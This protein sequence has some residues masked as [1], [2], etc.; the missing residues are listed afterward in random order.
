[1]THTPS[2]TIAWGTLDITPLLQAASAV[3]ITPHTPF[4]SQRPGMRGAATS[5]AKELGTQLRPHKVPKV[6]FGGYVTGLGKGHVS[7][8]YVVQ[9]GGQYVCMHASRRHVRTG[10]NNLPLQALHAS[11]DYRP[12][13]GHL[14]CHGVSFKVEARPQ[15]V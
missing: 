6:E 5:A 7:Y 2:A 14:R 15:G 8:P 10:S 4:G 12:A 9:Y 11:T 1:M 3:G 13:A